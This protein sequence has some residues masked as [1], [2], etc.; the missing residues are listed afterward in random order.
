MVPSDHGPGRLV[1]IPV[2]IDMASV[3]ELLAVAT[4]SRVPMPYAG[5]RPVATGE[6]GGDDAIIVPTSGSGGR[7]R[8]VRLTEG[9]IASA[10]DASN[11]RLGNDASDRW[12]LC[13]PL[14]HVGGLSV[15]WRSLKVGGSVALGPFDA[16][17]ERL[18]ARARPTIASLVPTMLSRVLDRD[19]S[20]ISDMRFVLVG[21]GA[22]PEALVSRAGRRSVA[23][24]STYGMTEATSQIATSLPDDRTRL[25]PLD[26]V[27]VGTVA[28]DGTAALVGERGRIT[29]DGPTVTPGFIG[30][31]PRQGPYI[32]NDV[33][34]IDADGSLTVVGR[35][36]DI[37][38]S[39]GENISLGAIAGAVSSFEG[40]SVAVAV[41][42]P[43][44]EWGTAVVGVVATDLDG[45]SL[46]TLA[47]SVLAPHERPRRWVIV[48][49]IPLL[50]NGKPDMAAVRKLAVPVS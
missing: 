48:D 35:M 23:V 29:I 32:T 7:Q 4:A 10:V 21:G 50:A 49:H 27:V 19:P 16:G 25:F 40:V 43:D 36:D 30:E 33:G 41:G 46:D 42:V 38:I 5:E 14:H 6:I 11:A 45:E 34:I 39:G 44:H 17:L 47:R 31:P 24:L 18:I 13:L 37:V 12:L 22:L 8:F 26:G 9:N 3:V 1:P 20:L 28:D 2:A 15:L